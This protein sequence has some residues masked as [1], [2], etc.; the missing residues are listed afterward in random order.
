MR[1]SDDHMDELILVKGRNAVP[2]TYAIILNNASRINGRDIAS[3]SKRMTIRFEYLDQGR[4][5]SIAGESSG[6]PIKITVSRFDGCTYD[7]IR[8]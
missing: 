8:E 4:A 3:I 2:I 7:S 6:F 5:T 1:A